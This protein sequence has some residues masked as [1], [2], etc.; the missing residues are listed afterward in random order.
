MISLRCKWKY[1]IRC[2]GDFFSLQGDGSGAEGGNTDDD[3]D[4]DVDEFVDDENFYYADEDADIEVAP[5]R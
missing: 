4:D 3:D 5:A 1:L 2:H